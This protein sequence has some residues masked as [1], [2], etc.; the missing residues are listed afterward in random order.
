MPNSPARSLVY[1]TLLLPLLAAGACQSLTASAASDATAVRPT[2]PCQGGTPWSQLYGP[3]GLNLQDG[4]FL[5]IPYGTAVL[6]DQDTPAL[7]GLWVDGTLCFADTGDWELRSCWILVTG[8]FEIGH[9]YVNPAKPFLHRATVTLAA[10]PALGLMKWYDP[11][12]PRD[13]PRNTSVLAPFAG[14]E[15]EDFC[16]DRG[17]VVTRDGQLRLFGAARGAAWRSLAQT[18]PVGANS[19]RLDAAVAGAWKIGDEIVIASSDFDMLQAERRIISGIAGDVV[20]FAPPLLYEHYGQI[21]E[22][23]PDD[24]WRMPVFAEVGN[25]T[26][27]VV[28]R[29]E[30]EIIHDTFGDR[31]STPGENFNTPAED[32]GHVVVVREI[33]GGA[34]AADQN[35]WFDVA[36]AEFRELSIEGKAGRYP[37][38]VHELADAR[39]A[40]GQKPRFE[41]NSIHDTPHRFLAV[42][43]SE[44]VIVRGNVGCATR[45]HGFFMEDT[46]PAAA[47]APNAATN[48]RIEDN[49][50]LL[51]ARLDLRH[52]EKELRVARTD[53]EEPAVF[54]I[55]HPDNRIQR[56][57]AAGAGGHGFWLLPAGPDGANGLP[58]AHHDN[59]DGDEDE[60]ES[61]FRDNVAHSNEQHGFYQ[62]LR[63]R[64]RNADP[65][66][67]DLADQIPAASGLIAWKNRR[68]G[69]WWRTLGR[70]D[71]AD[72]KI[73]DCR[74]GMYPA[75]TGTPVAGDLYDVPPGSGRQNGILDIGDVL[76]IGETENRGNWNPA[77]PQNLHQNAAGRTLPQRDM[78]FTDPD[79][80][81]PH[82]VPWDVLAGIEMYDGL[83]VVHD[84]RFAGF[85]D[86]V[87]PAPQGST[88]LFG[89]SSPATRESACITQVGYDSRYGVDPRSSV[90][91]LEF[92]PG[93]VQHKVLFRPIPN[94]QHPRPGAGMLRNTVVVDLDGT[95][96]GQGANR[97]VLFHD[98]AMWANASIAAP[99]VGNAAER[100]VGL[101]LA[102]EADFSMVKLTIDLSK[103]ADHPTRVRVRVPNFGGVN[104]FQDLPAAQDEFP[105]RF[106]LFNAITGVRPGSAQNG[107][108]ELTYPNPAAVAPTRIGLE[109][110]FSEREGEVLMIG[111]PLPALTS[112]APVRIDGVDVAQEPGSAGGFATR[113]ELLA[114]PNDQN[115]WTFDPAVQ[116][117]WLK[118]VS[119]LQDP[120]FAVHREG[121]R[122]E[123]SINP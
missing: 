42:H 53:F 64:W 23:Q 81:E 38:H 103:G 43:N 24:G 18:A 58:W 95:L 88:P 14:G 79:S 73:A 76:I 99:P 102:N 41:H 111:L 60:H 2:R 33:A 36:W 117:I 4:D 78:H 120:G 122:V 62:N 37:F 48:N 25:L 87:L 11:D 115:R 57:H 31:I 101:D 75:T 92:A 40:G 86:V 118:L 110:Q 7:G 68:Y 10:P 19:V 9:K 71:L 45:G 51:V 17:L 21:V 69:V 47:N 109:F 108:Y 67:P 30:A 22:I 114:S 107:I 119:R 50:G 55:M 121:T 16:L 49:L 96:A 12:D 72:L 27:N 85:A 106:W 26:R 8:I 1:L 83:N 80:E 113:A 32:R 44:Q 104:Q 97:Y 39:N 90:R 65:D 34:Y 100:W 98:A 13:P 56:N 89:H 5:H 61:W 3:A 52:Q 29:G 91:N 112:A 116:R 20:Q 63:P 105:E 46:A 28:I 35:P 59:F 15:I 123:V 84:V 74:A 94:M 54:W 66:D 77:D 70:A 93:T 6:L 82:F